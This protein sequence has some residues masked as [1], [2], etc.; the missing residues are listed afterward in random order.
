MNGGVFF[1]VQGIDICTFTD[2]KLDNE[3]VA[4]D[5]SQVEWS[6]TF[7]VDLIEEPR[8]CGDDLFNAIQILVFGTEMYGWFSGFVLF[9]YH[10]RLQTNKDLIYMLICT[11]L[12]NSQF[13]VE[14]R[15]LTLNL[16]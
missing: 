9:W 12:K 14:Y 15:G 6:V 3:A 5:D 1:V 11:E 16:F 4:R 10:M 13:F 8:I 7:L 2:E